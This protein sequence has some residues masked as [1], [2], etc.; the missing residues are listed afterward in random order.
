M[1]QARRL[2]AVLTPAARALQATP[3]AQV[4]PSPW[5]AAVAATPV[6]FMASAHDRRKRHLKLGSGQ[7]KVFF[8]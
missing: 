6:R 4:T 8:S 1:L 3:L 2:V 5:L 7:R